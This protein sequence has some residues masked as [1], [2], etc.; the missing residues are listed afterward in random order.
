VAPTTAVLLR[1]TADRGEVIPGG[2]VRYTITVQN[3]LLHAIRGSVVTDSFNPTYLSVQ[4]SG[5][6]TTM[7]NG[8]LQWRLPDLAPGQ[9]W[10]ASYVLGISKNAPNA[11][12]VNNIARITGPDVADASFN[13]RVTITQTGVMTQLPATGAAM[14]AILAMLMAPL[15][16]AAAVAQRRLMA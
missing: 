1:K 16:L 4:E 9:V 13:E 2:H 10:T 14:D 7:G 11:L 3:T 8:L 12:S 6:A 15:A 5:N